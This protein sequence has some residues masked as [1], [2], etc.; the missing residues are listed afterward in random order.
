VQAF[1]NKT[2]SA[3]QNAGQAVTELTQ[4]EN[5]CDVF[6]DPATRMLYV[7]RKKMRVRSDVLFGF[8]FGPNNVA[9]FSRQIDGS[10]TVNYHLTT[11]KAG[12]G[13]QYVADTSSQ[14]TFNLLEENTNLSDVVDPNILGAY[15]G[16][17]IAVR[18][19][20]RQL[21]SVT[22]FGW[23]SDNGVP[24]PL[25]D[26]A[27]GDQVHLVAKHSPRVNVDQMVRIFGMDIQIDNE[28]NERLGAL[29]L[30]P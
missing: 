30:A 15:S 26:Y 11:G 23:T 20:P 9:D 3:W 2:Y 22:P 16:A 17:E 7:Y 29:K 4:I 12:V 18:K 24:E 14:A 27:V 5:G 10:T 6:V 19:T 1:R 28:G 13:G 21:Y 25:V 8:Q